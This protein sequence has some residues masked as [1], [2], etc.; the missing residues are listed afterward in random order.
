MRADRETS[1]PMKPPP[2]WT[3][4]PLQVQAG[5]A[6]AEPQVHA[7][8]GESVRLDQPEVARAESRQA[9]DRSVIWKPPARTILADLRRRR[10]A[11]RWSGRAVRAPTGE[12]EGESLRQS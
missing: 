6:D 1:A 12:P 9:P 7:E 10:G 2:T 4:R 5:G 3:S 11:A 8:S